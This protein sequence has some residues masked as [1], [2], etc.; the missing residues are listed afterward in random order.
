LRTPMATMAVITTG[1]AMAVMVMV[2]T[3]R[4]LSKKIAS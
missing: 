2:A 1:I 4:G 3:I